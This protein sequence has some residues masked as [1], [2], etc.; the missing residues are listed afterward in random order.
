MRAQGRMIGWLECSSRGLP[1]IE[2]VPERNCSCYCESNGENTHH[3]SNCAHWGS[4]SVPHL[5]DAVGG[6]AHLASGS[7]GVH[8]V[9]DDRCTGEP[10]AN[11]S[12]RACGHAADL[13][14]SVRIVG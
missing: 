10:E 3:G 11:L 5:R 12:P 2:V 8:R 9:I 14:E 4:L 6:Q 7:D 13:F 1:E